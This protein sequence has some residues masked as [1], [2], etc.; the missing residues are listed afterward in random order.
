[1]SGTEL[2]RVDDVV[3]EVVPRRKIYP[4]LRLMILVRP[5]RGRRRVWDRLHQLEM[6]LGEARREILRV[7]QER[8][9]YIEIAEVAGDDLEESVDTIHELQRKLDIA[10][11][12][13]EAN[14]HRLDV[15]FERD[16]DEDDLATHPVPI[17]ELLSDDVDIIGEMDE[18][19]AI[20]MSSTGTFRVT[21]IVQGAPFTSGDSPS[22][23]P[24]SHGVAP[25]I[26][27]TEIK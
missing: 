22:D 24:L 7:S 6:E 21:N 8:D 16:V 10:I 1:M 18:L 23:F 20:S 12:A 2:A 25:N 17:V 4:W 13:N 14:S 5:T 15:T 9:R 27:I 26:S 3:V 19:P 11:R